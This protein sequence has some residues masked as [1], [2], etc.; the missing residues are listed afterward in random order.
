MKDQ[1]I[2]S[3]IAQTIEKIQKREFTVTGPSVADEEYANWI[4]KYEP[5][6]S[7][8]AEQRANASHLRYRPL[9][10]VVMPVW[11]PPIDLFTKTIE[12][13]F[14]Q[15]Y[16]NWELCLADGNSNW[17][18]KEVIR[19][20]VSRENRVRAQY[21]ARNQGISGN[22]NAAIQEAK[23]EFIALLDH[24]DLL[25]PNALF[26]VVKCLNENYDI[27]YIYSDMD[28]V[29]TQG[30]RTDPLFKPDW[31]P[32]M[33]ICNNYAT[34]LSV[35]RSRLVKDI[36]GFRAETEG[37]QDWDLILRVSEYAD[38]IFHVPKILYHWRQSPSSVSYAGLRAKPY[39][40]KSEL[41][42]L[43]EYLSRNRMHGRINQ[44]VPGLP[45]V[46]WDINRS[47]LVTVILID[48]GTQNAL[49]RCAHSVLKKSSYANFELIIVTNREGYKDFSDQRVRVVTTFKPLDFPSANNIGA[50]QAH[51]E[52]LVFLDRR[53][54]ISTSDWLQELT[55]WCSQPKIAVAGPQLISSDG[56]I[57][58]G[59]VIVGLPGCLFQGARMRW[60]SPLGYTEWYRNCLAVSRYGLTVKRSLFQEIGSFNENIGA[61][62]DVELCLRF[63]KM[64]YRIVHSPRAKLIFHDSQDTI[65]RQINVFQ[66]YRELVTGPDPYFNP[67]LS[68]DVPVPTLKV[69]HTSNLDAEQVRTSVRSRSKG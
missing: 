10:S 37:T 34:H 9:L 29:T 35:I 17:K 24:D 12:S 38:K 66:K 2:A 63:R 36:G 11:N 64:G 32:D 6:E 43:E 42:T 26:D 28:H 27:D 51:G 3:L 45:R 31:S 25:A 55:G 48:D 14:S 5:G 22:S 13:V 62:A 61:L 16:D 49:R 50:A 44:H 30:K 33:M 23:G 46:V 59:C 18:V 69:D 53:I 39:A 8:L 54:E 7:D 19:T 15:T 47:T 40:K 21:L 67:N 1:G 65:R 58:H 20:L 68:Y 56:I 41:L 60:H 52:V 4:A 57:T